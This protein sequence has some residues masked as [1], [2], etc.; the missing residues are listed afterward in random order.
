MEIGAM[1]TNVENILM[2][3]EY[4][5]NDL[6]YDE[7]FTKIDKNIKIKA[8]NASYRANNV[9]VH[10]SYEDF[11][12][13]FLEAIWNGLNAFISDRNLILSHVMTHRLKIAELTVWRRNQ[14]TGSNKDK[15]RITYISTRNLSL[16]S[17]ELD[18]KY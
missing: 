8:K 1:W 3:N 17:M 16:D 2:Q 15:N 12:S 14:H 11:Y 7:I 9:G 18:I 5:L 6:T 4:Q 13:Y 10:I